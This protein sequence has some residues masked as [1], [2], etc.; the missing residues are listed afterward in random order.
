MEKYSTAKNAEI[1]SIGCNVVRIWL[2]SKEFRNLFIK[3]ET[4][5]EKYKKEDI[6][7]IFEGCS[8]L[9]LDYKTDDYI[10]LEK[11]LG[12]NTDTYIRNFILSSIKE[13]NFEILSPLIE[14]L[15]KCRGCFSRC[16]FIQCIGI[17]LWVDRQKGSLNQKERLEVYTEILNHKMR[18]YE[19][20]YRQI[21]EKILDELMKRYSYSESKKYVE[22]HQK[23]LIKN[24]KIISEVEQIY[25]KDVSTYQ[26]AERQQTEDIKFA[27]KIQR[28]KNTEQ[29]VEALQYRRQKE[30]FPVP[31]FFYFLDSIVTKRTYIGR[32]D[33]LTQKIQA[34]IINS[35]YEMYNNQIDDMK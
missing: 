5:F 12:L 17:Q 14:A 32:D 4:R 35:S 9:Y 8:K 34:L 16:M 2:F 22:D 23:K 7:R 33:E 18:E 20:L 11:L 6:E 31:R 10:I 30:I 13:P 19:E 27:E 15:M 28:L 21:V 3:T 25:R 26:K 24:I 1:Y 29:I